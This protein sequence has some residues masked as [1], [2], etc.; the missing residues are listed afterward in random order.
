[1]ARKQRCDTESRKLNKIKYPRKCDTCDYISN[2]PTMFHYHKKTHYSVV[3]KICDYGCKQPAN[4]VSTRGVYCC[5]KNH[6]QC[7]IVREEYVNKVTIQWKRPESA[8]RKINTA[9]ST[10]ERLCTR[11]MIEKGRRAKWA[12]WGMEH[13][14]EEQWKDFRKYA[15]SCRALS[16]K[17]AKDNG[18]KIGLQTFHVDHIF[19]V[20][21]GFRNKVSPII[22]SHSANLR[23]LEAKKNSSKGCKSEITLEEL[24]T[25]TK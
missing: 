1:M 19:S 22:M 20:V 12:K 15:R 10:K 24:L 5:S 13:A 14:T 8:Q 3:D 23:I 17:W 9:I 2:N 21:D 25:L 7:P 18:Y 16:Q 4:F 6:M 11:E